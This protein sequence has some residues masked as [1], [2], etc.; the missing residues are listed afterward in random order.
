LAVGFEDF[1]VDLGTPI[2]S[3]SKSP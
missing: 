1:R 2:S 3:S